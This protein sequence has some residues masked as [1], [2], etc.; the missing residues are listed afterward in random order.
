MTFCS[1][2]VSC[3][4]EFEHALLRLQTSRGAAAGVPGSPNI[5][6][7]VVCGFTGD[8]NGLLSSYQAI[9]LKNTHG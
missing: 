9:V 8:G 6:S 4:T 7:N 3:M 1:R 5:R 2:D